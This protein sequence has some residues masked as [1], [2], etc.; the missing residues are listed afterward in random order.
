MDNA[1]ALYIDEAGATAIL[2]Q[3]GPVGAVDSIGADRQLV[4]TFDAPI[5]AGDLRVSVQDGIDTPGS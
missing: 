1:L 4:L 2:V 3:P 5:K